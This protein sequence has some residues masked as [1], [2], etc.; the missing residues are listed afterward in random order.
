MPMPRAMGITFSDRAVPPA[1]ESKSEYEIMLAL[2]KAI[3]A[4]AAAR[5][6]PST[7]GARSAAPHP[8]HAS[9][10]EQGWRDPDG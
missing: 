1:G 4:R 8:G 2:A 5:A 10:P 7:S 3:E 9:H 6:L